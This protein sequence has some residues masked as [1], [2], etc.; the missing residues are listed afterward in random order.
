M[1]TL[2]QADIFFF[3]TAIAVVLGT[4][5]FLIIAWYTVQILRDVREI[6]MKAKDA[7]GKLETD[8][9]I[10]RTEMKRKGNKASAIA[11]MVLAFLSSLVPRPRKKKSKEGDVL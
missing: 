11:D 6:S 8:F 2:V 4:L 1:E 7:A 9:D 10:L 3:I 5:A